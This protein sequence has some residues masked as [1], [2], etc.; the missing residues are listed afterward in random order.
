VAWTVSLAVYGTN[1]RSFVGKILPHR[2]SKGV[3]PWFLGLFLSLMR[4]E[5]VA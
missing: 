5:V 4:T 2:I 1:T 3:R